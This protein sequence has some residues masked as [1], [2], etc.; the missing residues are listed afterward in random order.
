LWM[1]VPDYDATG[2][3]IS[4]FAA[5]A[6]HEVAGVIMLWRYLKIRAFSPTEGALLVAACLVLCLTAFAYL[7]TP[8]GLGL[9]LVILAI[10]TVMERALFLHIAKDVLRIVKRTA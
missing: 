1:L 3:A 6:L 8:V 10:S 2:A 4:F 5:T 9:L 7:S